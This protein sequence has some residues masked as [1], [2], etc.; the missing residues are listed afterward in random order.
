MAKKMTYNSALEEI[1]IILKEIENGEID[2]DS[3]EQKL[4]KAKELFNYCEDKLHNAEKSVNQ[5]LDEQNEQ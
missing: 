1:N 3:L 4:L 5:I 2:V